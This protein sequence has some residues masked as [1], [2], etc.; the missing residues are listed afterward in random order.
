[1]NVKKI[2]IA[3]DFS[4]MPYGR[5]EKDGPDNGQRFREEYLLPALIKFDE[6]QVYMDGALGYGSSFL[7]E[8]FAGLFRNEGISKS[9]IKS[10]LKLFCSQNYIVESIWD[11]IEEARIERK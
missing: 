7:D 2:Y 8:A 4:D 6:V 5:Y 11:Y 9:E 1:M 10:K 3:D